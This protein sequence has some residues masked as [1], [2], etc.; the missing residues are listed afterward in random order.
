MECVACSLMVPGKGKFKVLPRTGHKGPELYSSFNL[1][2]RW[3]VGRQR[4]AP[5]ALPPG[6]PR[7]PLYRKLGGL[8]GRS[9]WVR[10]ISHPLGLNPLDRPG[11]VASRYTD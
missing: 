1:C 6:K 8:Q 3:G 4:H 10:K 5:S 7:Y 11:P 2:A 9:G